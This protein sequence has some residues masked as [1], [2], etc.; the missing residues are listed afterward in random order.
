MLPK[1]AGTGTSAAS[2]RIAAAAAVL[3]V[4]SPPMQ[5]MWLN[6]GGHVAAHVRRLARSRNVSTS[7]CQRRRPSSR[8][9]RRASRRPAPEPEPGVTTIFTARLGSPDAMD[10]VYRRS[11][12]RARSSG[13]PVL[14]VGV[15]LDDLVAGEREHVAAVHLE[16]RAVGCRRRDHPLRESAITRH[17]MAGLTKV[18]VRK[19]LEDP[20]ER[21]AH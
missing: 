5:T 16:L 4:V 2:Q 17:E 20:R 6:S 7:A 3:C 18:C 10:S 13:E 21:I 15:L 12:L 1:P 9:T 14:E 8:L 11:G 19:H